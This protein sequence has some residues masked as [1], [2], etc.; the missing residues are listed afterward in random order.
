M[1][2]PAIK[3]APERHVQIK[4]IAS[5]LGLSI[6]ETVARFI[7]REIADGTIPAGIDGVNV[8]PAG[9]GGLMI[10]FD[11]HPP[12]HFSPEAVADLAATL[13]SF[14]EA[15][16]RANILI[17]MDRNFKIERKGNG[18]KL[19]V[20]FT[21][22]ITKSFACDLVRDLADHLEQGLAGSKAA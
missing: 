10:G 22:K 8:L 11:D 14:A 16:Q 21:G 15:G 19:T 2:A 13:R 1:S 9:D 4:A 3:L 17:K 5:A 6:A 18:V 7:N 12:V 20:P